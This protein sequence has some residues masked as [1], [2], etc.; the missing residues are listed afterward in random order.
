MRRSIAKLGWV[1]ALQ[2]AALLPHAPA[3]AACCIEGCGGTVSWTS[4]GINECTGGACD[5][6]IGS[7][8]FFDANATCGEGSPFASCPPDEVGQCA[9]GVNNDAWTG[10]RNTDCE[11][12]DCAFDPFCPS[13]S[14]PAA[15][16]FGIA[17]TALVL[18]A[19]GIFTLRSR[20]RA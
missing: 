15:G 3:R 7:A 14:V 12:P 11:D 18:L 1:M 17:V 2:F 13:A 8:V 19:F 5:S 4:C 9:D 20:L 10:D 16:G 6:A